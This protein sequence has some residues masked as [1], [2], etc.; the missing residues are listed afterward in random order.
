[1]AQ[2]PWRGYILT[3]LPLHRVATVIPFIDYLHKQRAP[4]ERELRR[5]RLPVQAMDD[6]DCFIPS[7]NYW[8]FIAN[9]ARHKGMENLGFQVGMHIGANAVDPGL[10]RRLARLPSLQ[11]ALERFCKIGSSEISRVDLW[12][13][14]ASK[15]THRLRYQ[16]SFG[17][18]H[19]AH[20]QF[21]WYGLM[22][23]IAAIRLFAGKHW[24]PDEIG[25]VSKR[26]PG[27]SI[28][29]YFPNTQF[30]LGQADCFI[31]LS[32]R[33]LDKC[34][35]LIEDDLVSL[36]R[37]ARIKPPN[38]FIGA[39]KL[40]LR[41]Y[42][43]DGAPSVELAATIAGLSPRTLQRRLTTENL[44]YRQL[45]VETR[46]EAA[47]DLLETS[48]HTITEIASRLGYS[49]ASHFARAFRSIA[50]VSPRAYRQERT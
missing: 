6:P 30:F 48:T 36:P 32:N 14:P 44:S 23:I 25:L 13:T 24:Q 43:R 29:G 34:P 15:G 9:T 17:C 47:A 49:D 45:L 21:E 27:K 19:P 20:V 16:T 28:R 2:L 35:Q 46:Y 26:T 1:M 18:D 31:T 7:R 38:D 11:Q 42:L 12:L 41:S 5:A 40:A 33:M 39:F 37:Y 8:T 4:V 3:T 10:A 50:G 22:A